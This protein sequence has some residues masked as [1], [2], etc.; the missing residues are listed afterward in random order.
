MRD[1]TLMDRSPTEQHVAMRPRP[2]D[3]LKRVDVAVLADDRLT[4]E[5][6]IACLR[7]HS[8][9]RIVPANDAHL[10]DV[11]LLIVQEVNTETMIQLSTIARRSADQPAIVLVTNRIQEQ[12][13]LHAVRHGL[14]S[15]VSRR[16]ASADQL[17]RT[18]HASHGG[19]AQ[20]PENMLSALMRQVRSVQAANPTTM[21]LEARE[22]EVLRLVAEGLDYA[23]ISQRLNFCEGTITKVVQRVV[24]RLGLR[25]RTH[26]VAVALRSGTL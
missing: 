24:S 22:I 8:T 12:H 13:V 17:L 7:P 2:T 6:T 26:A 21:T 23:E 18:V 25:N 16:D 20:F 1:T 14:V 5:G 10:A 9:V 4:A 19:Q 3:S 15:I 11:V